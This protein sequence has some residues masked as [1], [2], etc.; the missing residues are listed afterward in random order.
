LGILWFIDKYAHDIDQT[1][2]RLGDEYPNCAAVKLQE[3]LYA[4]IAHHTKEDVRNDRSI[5]GRIPSAHPAP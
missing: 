5:G 2:T 4:G 3:E 1:N